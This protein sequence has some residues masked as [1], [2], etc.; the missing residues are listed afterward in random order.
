MKS[1]EEAGGVGDLVA[2][3]GS[4]HVLLEAPAFRSSKPKEQKILTR[5]PP[6]YWRARKSTA[7]AAKEVR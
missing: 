2:C 5:D 7:Q 4:V 6:L 1:D 3:Q